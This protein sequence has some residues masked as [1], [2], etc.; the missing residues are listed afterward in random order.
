MDRCEGLSE[1]TDSSRKC[2]DASDQTKTTI[3]QVPNENGQAGPEQAMCSSQIQMDA[4]D[5]GADHEGSTTMFVASD[6]CK[7]PANDVG[8]HD[9]IKDLEEALARIQALE[10]ANKAQMELK[11]K[12]IQSLRSTLESHVSVQNSAWKLLRID[13]RTAAPVS[14]IPRADK[15]AFK[16]KCKNT[17]QGSGIEGVNICAHIWPKHSEEGLR[18]MF[19]GK[20]SIHGGENLLLLQKPIEHAFDSGRIC[21]VLATLPGTREKYI[22]IKVLDESIRRDTIGGSE[23]TFHDLEE[24][25]LDLTDHV[26]SGTLLSH[27]SQKA[28]DFA[29]VKKWIGS[30]EKESLMALAKFNS[31]DCAKAQQVS[32]WL[33][34]HTPEGSPRILPPPSPLTC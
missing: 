14:N 8:I 29:Y 21:F 34:S 10:I 4:N 20:Y 9:K 18:V 30:P 22:R 12:E 1:H 13:D 25:F 2:S 26:V 5:Y 33:R 32:E 24:R 3:V 23:L 31:P 16:R 28:I 7:D 6:N 11:D 15:R 17:C 19:K 27:H